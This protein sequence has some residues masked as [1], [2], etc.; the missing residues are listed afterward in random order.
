MKFKAGKIDFQAVIAAS[1]AGMGYTIVTNAISNSGTLGP[2]WNKEK[3]VN[4][5]V[6]ASVLGTGLLYF[7]PKAKWAHPA[8]Y[9][10]LGAGGA[11]AAQVITSKIKPTAAVNGFR[12]KDAASKLYKYSPMGLEAAAVKKLLNREHACNCAT[13]K[14]LNGRRKHKLNGVIPDGQDLFNFDVMGLN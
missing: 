14:N 8:G 11:V 7:L 5:A 1:V 4:Y 6:Y 12:F 9:G 10:L 13:P 3:D 2:K